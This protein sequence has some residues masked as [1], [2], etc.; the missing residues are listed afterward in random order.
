VETIEEAVQL[1]LEA[2][3]Q[4]FTGEHGVHKKRLFLGRFVTFLKSQG[5][6][7]K[8]ADLTLED[9]QDFLD[10]LTHTLHGGKL[11]PTT[12]KR[13]KCALRSFSRFLANS[14]FLEQDLFFTLIIE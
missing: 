2:F 7:M 9:G 14:D 13:Y 11:S 10:S 5:H 3:S 12:K 6:S 1:Y 8:L 4:Q